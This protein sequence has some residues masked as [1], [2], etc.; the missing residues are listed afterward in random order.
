MLRSLT[1]AEEAF[2]RLIDIATDVL[3]LSARMTIERGFLGKPKPTTT[4]VGYCYGF[5]EEMADVQLGV[6]EFERAA[7]VQ[8]VFK[9]LFGKSGD[10]FVRDL[11]SDQDRYRNGLER[12]IR[13]YREWNQGTRKAPLVPRA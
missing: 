6:D 12:G 13:E 5:A 9:N 2:F 7:F 11:I 1:N 4:Q 10:R 8:L 3:G